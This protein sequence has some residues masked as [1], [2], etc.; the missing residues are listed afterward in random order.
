MDSITGS[1]NPNSDNEFST[2]NFIVEKLDKNTIL[3]FNQTLQNYL[4]TAIGSTVCNLTRFDK[5]QL[6]DTIVIKYPNQGR[7][8]LHQWNVKCNDQI[9]SGEKTNFTESSKTNTPTRTEGAKNVH[10]I[11]SSFVY[12]EMSGEIFRSN[13]Y[14]TFERTGLIQISDISF[15]YIRYS[16]P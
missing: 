14:C 6:I 4:K 2:K 10:P 7:C 16:Y 8:L 12:T 1:R 5:N 11:V 3:R 15:Y 13:V 9:D